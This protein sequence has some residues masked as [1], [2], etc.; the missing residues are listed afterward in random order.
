MK[1]SHDVT[2]PAAARVWRGL[3]ALVLERYDRRK[4]V[5][6]ALDMSFI[7]AKALGRLATGPMT[8]RELAA[9]LSTDAPYTTLVVDDLERRGLVRRAAHP[10][11]RRSKIVTATPAGVAAAR[12][13][14][15][16]LNAP[17]APVLELTEA[18]LAALDRIVAKLLAA[19]PDR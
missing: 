9:A 12:H 4:E 8:M 5:S 19:G 16:I 17:P 14:E 15:D 3:R 6:A 13:A 11:D 2:S 1:A 18:E 10:T 7:R